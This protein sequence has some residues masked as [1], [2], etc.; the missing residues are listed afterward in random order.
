[1]SFK[2]SPNPFSQSHVS[3][4]QLK[5]V[6]M[7]R[8]YKPGAQRHVTEGNEAERAMRNDEISK[9]VN[10][11]ISKGMALITNPKREELFFELILKIKRGEKDIE[12]MTRILDKKPGWAKAMQGGGLLYQAH[13]QNPR[14][15]VSGN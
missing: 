6:E 7:S 12:I 3:P 13:L 9:D 2:G 8:G 11:F 14:R 1:M 5:G 4:P 10:E 15:S